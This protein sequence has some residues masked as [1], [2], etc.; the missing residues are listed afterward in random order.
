MMLCLLESEFQTARIWAYFYQW[1]YGSAVPNFFGTR[2]WF[3]EDGFSMDRGGG[4]GMIQMH[5]IYS[6]L[7]FYYCYINTT[8]DQGIKFWRL[9]TPELKHIWIAY[10]SEGK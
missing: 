6:V 4:F 8:S 9:E 10:F 2:D 7:C 3:V 5:Y 1:N